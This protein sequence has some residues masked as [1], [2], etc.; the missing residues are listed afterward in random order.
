MM[1]VLCYFLCR[2]S[3]DL[4]RVQTLR[5]YS[6]AQKTEKWLNLNLKMGKRNV[7]FC[8]TMGKP[9]RVRYVVTEFSED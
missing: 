6:M 7:I 3:S 2:V 8:I 5:S 1:Y 9:Y 4:V